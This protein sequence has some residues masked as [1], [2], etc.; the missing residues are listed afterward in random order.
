MM[1]VWETSLDERY[2]CKVERIDEYMGRLTVVDTAAS[3]LLLE[4]NVTL[5]YNAV[6]GADVADV[7]LWQEMC[8]KAVDND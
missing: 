7:A 8:I 2:D 5:A 6:F 3:V 4:E 1:Y